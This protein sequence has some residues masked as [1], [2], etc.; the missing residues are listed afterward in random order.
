MHV[1]YGHKESYLMMGQAWEALGEQQPH[2][3][4]EISHQLG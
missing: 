2:H 1:V 4:G 3:P